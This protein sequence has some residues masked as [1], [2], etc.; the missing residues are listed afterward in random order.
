MVVE[1]EGAGVMA[2]AVVVA[3]GATGGIAVAVAAAGIADVASAS[4]KPS[5][6]QLCSTR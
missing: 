4:T 6:F 5:L 3:A 1:A 2:A